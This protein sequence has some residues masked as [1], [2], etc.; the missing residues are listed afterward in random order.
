MIITS[1][2]GRLGNQLFQYAFAISVSRKLNIMYVINDTTTNDAVRKYFGIISV[3]DYKWIRKILNLIDY[4]IKLP[5]DEQSSF[6]TN[7]Q[8]LNESV[9][10]T[11]YVG[12]YQSADF[13]LENEIFLRR[14]LKLKLK[15]RNS[16]KKKFI[17]LFN[18][19]TL[20]IHYR[21]GD[22]KN[23]GGSELGGINLCLPDSYYENALKLIKNKED[24][25]IILVT[26]DIEAAKHKLP[27]I[28]HKFFVTDSEIND[29]QLLMHADVLIISNS[30]FAWWG[31]YLNVK[32]AKIFAPE[33]WLGFKIKKEFP[34]NIIPV[35]FIKVS[36][37]C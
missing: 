15:Y 24:Y 35:N 23:F 13:F 5:K 8:I 18:T 9:N 25:Q 11:H 26:D 31:A 12:C 36:F 19:K 21:I 22:F 7:Q 27:D 32:N 3:T 2:N 1:L 29:L 16:F 6:K 10:N 14:K 34:Y 30:T 33:Y 17:H 28:K 20:V 4:I 37:D